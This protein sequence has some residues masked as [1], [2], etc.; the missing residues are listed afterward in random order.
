MA[1]NLPPSGFS[2]SDVA[3]ANVHVPAALFPASAVLMV[4]Y[5]RPDWNL[6]ADILHPQRQW[7]LLAESRGFSLHNLAPANAILAITLSP[8]SPPRSTRFRPPA[9]PR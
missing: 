1:I 6:T 9:F 7:P 8:S 5:E 4:R 3:K 2:A